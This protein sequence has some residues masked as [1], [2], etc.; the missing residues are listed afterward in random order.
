MK[1]YKY[2]TFR[3]F[4]AVNIAQSILHGLH[5]VAAARELGLEVSCQTIMAFRIT[6]FDYSPE[7]EILAH[8]LEAGGR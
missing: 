4:V 7:N 1:N 2:F 5:R 3:N 8:A 6:Q